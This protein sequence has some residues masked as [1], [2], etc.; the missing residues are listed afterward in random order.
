MVQVD[1][2]WSYAL[3]AGFA[4]ANTWQLDAER[5]AGRSAFDHRSFRNT[6]LFLSCVFVPSG[7]YLVWAF[8]SW[9]TMHVGTRDM[10]AWLITLFSLTNVTQG[11]LGYAVVNHLLARGKPYAA[12]LQFVAGYFAMFFI[13]V[14]GWDGTGYIRFFSETPEQIPNWTWATAGEWLMCPVAIALDVMGV[15]FLPPML[16]LM[17]TGVEQGLALAG[18]KPKSRY[19]VSFYVLTT[20]GR[21]L[22]MAILLSVSIRYLSVWIGVPVFAAFAYFVALRKGGIFHRHFR[23]LVYGESFF[24]IGSPSERP[25]QAPV[26]VRSAGP[27]A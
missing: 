23:Q 7:A 12:Y 2:F 14:H 6:L 18:H 3:G 27:S 21:V 9:E 4:I 8:P 22:V 20:A 19:L 5:K 15:F 13:L 16:Y 26:A 10:P 1:V 11:I 25:S 17:G 24:G